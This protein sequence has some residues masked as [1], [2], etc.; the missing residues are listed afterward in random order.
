MNNFWNKWTEGITKKILLEDWINEY[1]ITNYLPINVFEPILDN[2]FYLNE[3]YNDNAL[4]RKDAHVIY[5]QFLNTIKQY[6]TQEELDQIN[7]FRAFHYNKAAILYAQMLNYPSSVPHNF[8]I[9]TKYG[10]LNFEFTERSKYTLDNNIILAYNDDTQTI[11]LFV[12]DINNIT[13][14]DILNIFRKKRRLIHEIIH[15]IDDRLNVLNKNVPNDDYEYVN[16]PS[17][18]KTISQ[19]LISEFGRYLFKHYKNIDRNKLNNK[20]YIFD[21]LNEFLSTSNKDYLKRHTEIQ[22][23]I[24][25]VSLFSDVHKKELFNKIVEYLNYIYNTDKDIDLKDS[26]LIKNQL[27]K[28]YRAESYLKGN[29]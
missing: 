10:L 21:L 26:T 13:C 4:E 1:I 17:E 6:L 7:T 27:I 18:Y 29:K 20:E 22:L 9:N 16:S 25:F 23:F 14:K 24:N 11:L 2:K 3:D 28:L 19:D 15:F 12:D 8:S 5:I